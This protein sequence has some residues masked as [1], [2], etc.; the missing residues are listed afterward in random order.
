MQQIYKLS[1]MLLVIFHIMAIL[2]KSNVSSGVFIAGVVLS[3]L[4]MKAMSRAF[5][6]IT[7]VFFLLG[8]GGLWIYHQPIAVWMES[9][10]NMT[11]FV[12]ILVVMQL[13]TIP[14][15]AGEYDQVLCYW[16]KKFCKSSGSLFVFTMLVTHTMSS[17]LSMGTVPVVI[18]LF[19]DT[20]K[21]QVHNP[22]RFIASAVSRSFT[23]GTLWAPGA[24]T[25]FLVGQVTGVSWP[26][27]FVPSLLIG[28]GGMITSYFLELGEGHISNRIRE[29]DVR[30]EEAE[31]DIK[32]RNRIWHILL[33]ITALI[34][35]TMTFIY[36]QVAASS[37]GIIL[38]GLLVVSIWMIAL[39]KDVKING[40]IKQYWEKDLLKAADL[41]PFF[42]AIGVF[43]GAFTHSG[44][45]KVIELALQGYAEELGLIM[46]FLIP[47]CMVIL[48]LIGL[49]PLISIV[50]LGQMLMALHLSLSPLVLALCLNVGSSIS[51]MLS[52]FAGVIVAIAVLINAKA[53]EVAIRWNWRFCA[54]YFVVGIIL[55]YYLGNLFS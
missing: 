40:F 37:D 41:A 39:R 24:A 27:I 25:I 36:L 44:L 11:N 16:L 42:V 53:T 8:I 29:K 28:L 50:I 21:K 34:L 45:D 10:N 46:L 32:S 4:G 1:I 51:Y 54:I 26:K 15:S 23:L 9:F 12:A 6:G 47:L 20:I 7:V 18:N 49:H 2:S 14:I 13:F 3:L 55:A 31:P 43:S 52:P 30:I 19:Q 38:S 33:A 17:F 35:F 48:S 5:R 22:K